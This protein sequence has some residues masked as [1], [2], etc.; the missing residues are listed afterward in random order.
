MHHYMR[1]S[2]LAGSLVLTALFVG[3]ARLE[4][5]II[6]YAHL[7]PNDPNNFVILSNLLNG[8]VPGIVVGDKAFSEF[9]YTTLPVDDMPDPEDITIFGF[10]DNDGNFGLSFH[11]VFWDLPGGGPSDALLRF[12]VEVTPDALEEGWRISDAHL[13][14]G[15]VGIGS[16]SFLAVD[17]SFQGVNESLSTYAT[18]LGGA[19][20]QV[21]ADEVVFDQL[22]TKLRVTKDILAFSGDVEIPA[23]ISVIDQSFSQ[24]LIPEPSTLASLSVLGL[25]LLASRR[26]SPFRR[27]T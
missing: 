13:F 25:G 21:L 19:S 18:T 20:Q 22:F 7:E 27:R 16:N 10:Q 12:T 8:E 2:I 5:T 9:F 3:T 26:R 1:R 15:G 23:T 4:A 11:A 17:E 14:M 6:D 24:E